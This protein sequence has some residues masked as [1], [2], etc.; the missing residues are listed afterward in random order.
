MRGKKAHCTKEP[1]GA[2]PQAS[3]RPSTIWTINTPHLTFRRRC[4]CM[5]SRLSARLRRRL[6]RS[7]AVPKRASMHRGGNH[8]SSTRQKKKSK[9]HRVGQTRKTDAPR[10]CYGPRQTE[11]AVFPT[12]AATPSTPHPLAPQ[13]HDAKLGICPPP[14]VPPGPRHGRNL[15]PPPPPVPPL[16]HADFLAFGARADGDHPP[17]LRPRLPVDLRRAADPGLEPHHR[18]PPLRKPHRRHAHPQQR[19]VGEVGQREHLKPPIVNGHGRVPPLARRPRVGEAPR[20]RAAAVRG[21]V[22][23]DEGLGAGRHRHLHAVDGDGFEEGGGGHLGADEHVLGAE[24]EVGG[25]VAAARL[26]AVRVAPPLFVKGELDRRVDAKGDVVDHDRAGGGHRRHARH[27][28]PPH[29]EEALAHDPPAAKVLDERR[30]CRRAGILDAPPEGAADIIPRAEGDGR[31]RHVG[32]AARLHDRGDPG[33]GAVAASDKGAHARDGA[34]ARSGG[35]HRRRRRRRGGGARHGVEP[36][37]RPAVGLDVVH[38]FGAEE[39]PEDEEHLGAPPPPRRRVDKRNDGVGG[40]RRGRGGVPAAAAASISRRAAS[41]IVGSVPVVSPPPA[42]ERNTSTGSGGS[43]PGQGGRGG[44]GA[45]RGA[46]AG[47]RRGRRGG[48]RHPR[49]PSGGGAWA[50][51]SMR[52]LARGLRR[53]RRRRWHGD[54]DGT[55]TAPRQGG[56]GGRRRQAAVPVGRAARAVDEAGSPPPSAVWS[57]PHTHPDV[58]RRGVAWNG[59]RGACSRKGGAARGG[60]A[61][62]PPPQRADGDGDDAAAS[63]QRSPVRPGPPRVLEQPTGYDLSSACAAIVEEYIAPAVARGCAGQG[64]AS[65]LV[66]RSGPNY[67]TNRTAPQQVLDTARSQPRFQCDPPHPTGP[68]SSGVRPTYRRVPRTA[69]GARGGATAPRGASSTPRSPSP[70]P[71]TGAS[72]ADAAGVV[73]ALRRGDPVMTATAVLPPPTTICAAD[74]AVSP[75]P[76]TTLPASAPAVVATSATALLAVP[77]MPTAP[78]RTPV[79]A[80][81]IQVPAAPTVAAACLPV[82]AAC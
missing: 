54:K 51:G 1:D 40:G 42:G 39:L 80:R 67:H 78:A 21:D 16:F 6:H 52:R 9:V 22:E 64:A 25:E 63:L 81:A 30:Q 60:V 10:S 72:T 41:A 62:P 5:Q 68:S 36:P 14:L 28:H 46:A 73:A 4:R 33:E 26:V 27:R 82:S 75:A 45:P 15:P 31:E 55:P 8:T 2:P 66:S 58:E 12:L 48:R 29:V 53:A 37:P 76:A 69:D 74:V 56:R 43:C 47:C 34:L 50:T 7:G 13:S 18:Q 17:L 59:G 70:N 49:H 35:R 32:Q 19:V 65:Q 23:D 20:L 71:D 79:A 24:R 38:R 11:A 77:M 57:A 3:A 61:R 44:G